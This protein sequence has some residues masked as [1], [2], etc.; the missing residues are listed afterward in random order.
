M[1]AGCETKENIQFIDFKKKIFFGMG[2]A[3]IAVRVHEDWLLVMMLI[4]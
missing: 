3:Y 1:P 4:S 2:F